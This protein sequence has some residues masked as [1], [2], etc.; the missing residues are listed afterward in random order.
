MLAGLI[1][2]IIQRLPGDEILRLGV[3]CGAAAASLDGTAVGSFSL[4]EAHLKDVQMG[5]YLS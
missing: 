4:V 5:E 3:A 2:G 1:K